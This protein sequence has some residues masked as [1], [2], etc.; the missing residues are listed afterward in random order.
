[1]TP[2]PKH[3]LES[4]SLCMRHPCCQI[5]LGPVR[6]GLTNHPGFS[7]TPK[8]ELKASAN[9]YNRGTRE[10]PWRWMS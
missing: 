3:E 2:M 1:M 8:T 5:G 7:S 10:Q 9:G 6:D 4:V